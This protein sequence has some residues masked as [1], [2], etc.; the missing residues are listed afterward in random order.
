MCTNSQIFPSGG[1][2]MKSMSGNPKKR[3][4][5]TLIELLVVI[6]IIAILVSLLLPAVQ[7]AREAA[8][9]S[10][11]QNNLKQM[12][13]AIYNYESAYTRFPSSGEST[14]ES[15]AIRQFFPISLHTAI[16]PFIDETALSDQWNY[17]VHYTTLPNAALARTPLPKFTCPSNSITGA[18]DLQYGFTD[19]MPI[20]YTD[21]DPSTGL[22]NKSAGGVLNAD[23]A[24]CLGFCRRVGQV[25]DGLSNTMMV[26][27]DANRPTQ[28]AGSYD[29]TT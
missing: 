15:L 24:G 18:N 14:N 13:L 23:R 26:I 16:L 9:R 20:A 29:I 17:S 21:I 12:G 11:C 6:A 3:V 4:G 28:T 7:Q 10:N 8:R 27:E 22:R 25:T 2:T 19:Y 1:E 5:F